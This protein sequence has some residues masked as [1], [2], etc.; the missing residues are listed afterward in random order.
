[1]DEFKK[2]TNE[3]GKIKADPFETRNGDNPL[4]KK[5]KK[6]QKKIVFSNLFTSFAFSVVF[7][8]AAWVWNTYPDEKIQFY[9]SIAAMFA[10]LGITL[11]FLWRRILYWR[12][13]SLSMDSISF[14]NRTIKKLNYQL[15]LSRV[16]TPFYLITLALI[17]YFYLDALVAEASLHFKI[18]VYGI[19]FGW[20]ISAGIYGYIRRNRK[21]NR[22][23]KP[24]L[25]ELNSLRDNLL[26]K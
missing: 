24:L 18:L 9:A 14:L 8:I 7:I 19:T 3:W 11:F 21:N 22:V 16:F 26:N 2:L 20:I 23:I 6:L 17:F 1:M 25:E 10:L 13:P 12:T 4:I 15:W 5:L